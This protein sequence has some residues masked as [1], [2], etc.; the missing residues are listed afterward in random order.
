MMSPVMKRS[1]RFESTM[2]RRR[3][4]ADVPSFTAS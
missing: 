2:A 1:V 3:S 4:T